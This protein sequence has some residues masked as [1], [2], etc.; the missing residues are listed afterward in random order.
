MTI[1][2][3]PSPGEYVYNLNQIQLMYFF[4][5]GNLH[6]IYYIT[7][8]RT[9]FTLWWADQKVISYNSRKS[10]WSFKRRVAQ[11]PTEDYLVS[12][13]VFIHLSK[14][15]GKPLLLVLFYHN[16]YNILHAG[17]CSWHFIL[18]MFLHSNMITISLL[19]QIYLFCKT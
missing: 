13:I 19:H 15:F 10:K 18:M 2:G 3:I 5:S 12:H 14:S 11:Y 4:A 7:D 8:G 9:W 6:L 17:S 1:I 16:G